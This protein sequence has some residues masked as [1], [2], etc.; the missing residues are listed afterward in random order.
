[1][2]YFRDEY[3]A[4]IRDRKCPARSCPLLVDYQIDADKCNGCRLCAKDC[5]AGAIAG[6]KKKPHV[7][8]MDKCI[9]CG[10]CITVCTVEAV[11]KH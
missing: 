6:E 7:I 9:K 1:M 3:E 10:K 2:K 4:H 8:D 11:M 5:A